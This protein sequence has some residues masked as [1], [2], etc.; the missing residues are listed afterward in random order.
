MEV[1]GRGP[2][3][4][5]GTETRQSASMEKGLGVMSWGGRLAGEQATYFGSHDV[6]LLILE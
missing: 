2:S 6:V 4:K 1:T 3:R 5:A